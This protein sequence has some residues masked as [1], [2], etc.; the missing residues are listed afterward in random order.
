MRD[1]QCE[2][3]GVTSTDVTVAIIR[4][5]EGSE[6]FGTTL[7]CRDHEACWERVMAIGDE[8]LVA[9]GRPRRP[10]VVEFPKVLA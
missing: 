9:D 8:W 10:G 3:C 5:R 6:R 7:R 1:Q 4:W 2:L